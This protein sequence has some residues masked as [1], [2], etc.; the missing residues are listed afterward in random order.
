MF[1]I[2][3]NF[4]VI[5]CR[6]TDQ[7]LWI[8]LRVKR[9]N[10]DYN[11][12]EVGDTD[13]AKKKRTKELYIQPLSNEPAVYVPPS[14]GAS[15]F[16]EKADVYLDRQEISQESVVGALQFVYQTWNRALSRSDQRL[17]LGQESF[18]VTSDDTDS[19]AAKSERLKKAMNSLQNVTYQNPT[20]LYFE[21]GLDGIPFLSTARNMALASLQEQWKT[22]NLTLPPGM[23]LLNRLWK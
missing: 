16:F 11:E 17:K 7:P 12:A 21:F 2:V 4:L 13:A 19:L 5:F 20:T 22:D 14:L 23:T 10:P 15:A 18:I 3:S 1:Y 9:T 6:L 8:K